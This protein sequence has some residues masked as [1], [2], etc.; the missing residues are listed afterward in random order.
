MTDKFLPQDTDAEESI[1]SSILLDAS[2]I[3]KIVDKLPVDA[4]YLSAHQRIYKAAVELYYQD[5]LT[6]ITTVGSWLSDH[7]LLRNVGGRNKLAQLANNKVSTDNI[8]SYTELVLEKYKRRQLIEAGTKIVELGFDTTIDL[9]NIIDLSEDKIF[10]ITENKVDKF[11]P[12]AISNS[13]ALIVKQLGQE[14][15]PALS[16]GLMD[17][18]KLMGG[19]LNEDLIVIAARASM[20]KTWLGCH[21]VNH[22][23]LT[24]NLPVVFFSA[25][26]NKEQLT[27][28]FLAMHA[29]ID[30][31][32]LIHNKV[33]K[34]EIA[35]LRK[36]LE[37]LYSLPIIIDDTP[38]SLQNPTKMRSALR[39][40]KFERGNLGLIV[41]DYIQKLGDR[42]ASNRAQAVGKF[43]GAFKDLAKEFSCPFVAL[44]QI[45]RGVENQTD[46]RPT[47]ADIK[48]SGDIEQDMDV[49]LLL[50]RDEYYNSNTSDNG[51]MEI[52]VAKNR[53]GAT[54]VCK[55][56]FDATIG[57]FRNITV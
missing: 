4:F 48:D 5:K 11:S 18:D 47:I 40:I 38:A 36:A 23:A 7:K 10:K 35:K 31:H 30:S 3:S 28:R 12:E 29:K 25:E 53:N 39:R 22:I 49:G 27:K 15:T 50:Y 1:L 32:R 6:D 9:E 16:T 8:D 52:N 26:T 13:L 24:Y 2:A 43:S 14:V 44:A 20:G 45:N 57:E 55:V 37:V 42:A 21:F 33:Y 34:S 41:M 56:L 51:V 19:L 54:G 46:K 17:L